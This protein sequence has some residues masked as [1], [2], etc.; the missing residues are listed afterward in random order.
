MVRLRSTVPPFD[1]AFIDLMVP[2]HE[3]AV[4]VAR[5][6]EQHATR[7]EVKQLAQAIAESQQR[8]IDQLR[9]WRQSWFGDSRG[10]TGPMTRG[11]GQGSS[12]TPA[13]DEHGH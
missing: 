10:D 1:R 2:H 13:A 8:E 4:E 6:A 9:H 12:S 11:D 7:T 3:S 5:L